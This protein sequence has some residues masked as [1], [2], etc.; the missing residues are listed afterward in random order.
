MTNPLYRHFGK[1]FN[2]SNYFSNLHHSHEENFVCFLIQVTNFVQSYTFDDISSQSMTTN[3]HKN[4]IRSTLAFVIPFASSCFFS[5]SYQLAITF[6][7]CMI[8]KSSCPLITKI[9]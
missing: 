6:I 9:N 7:T 2:Q 5:I 4:I 3:R 8:S 1:I